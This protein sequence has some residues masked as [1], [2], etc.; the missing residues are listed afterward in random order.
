[1]R[2]ITGLC[3][4]QTEPAVIR[5]PSLGTTYTREKVVLLSY[6]Q[7]W[8]SLYVLLGNLS[9]PSLLAIFLYYK[10]K[11]SNFFLSFDS[12]NMFFHTKKSK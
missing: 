10:T 2:F 3:S 1:M 5:E 9:N 6:K 12:K 11:T 7:M 8:K 4:Q